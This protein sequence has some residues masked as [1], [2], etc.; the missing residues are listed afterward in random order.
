[1]SLPS[2]SHTIRALARQHV[3]TRA[4]ADGPPLPL[5][6]PPSQYTGSDMLATFVAGVAFGAVAVAW[7]S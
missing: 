4:A 3:A 7:L 5:P 6:D 1:M 2:R